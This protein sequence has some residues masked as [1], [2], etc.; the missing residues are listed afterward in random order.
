MKAKSLDSSGHTPLDLAVAGGKRV[1][2][3]ALIMSGVDV[4][5]LDATNDGPLHHAIKGGHVGIAKDLLLSGNNPMQARSNGDFPIHLAD[6]HGLDEA[7]LA[8]V[9]KGIDLNCVNN[10][11]DTPL[12]MAMVRNHVVT[13]KVLLAAG[14]DPN[15]GLALHEAASSNKQLPSER[16]SKPEPISM[17][18]VG[19]D[20]LTGSRSTLFLVCSH[21]SSPATGSQR[22]RE[23]P[24]RNNLGVFS[25]PSL[26]GRP[27]VEI[28][29]GR[30]DRG[31]RGRDRRRYGDTTH[32]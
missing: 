17:V 11:R 29:C 26:R 7:V 24:Q 23:D 8:L 18:R 14:A 6:W 4:D 25:R 9:Q 10:E 28:G 31:L 1:A 22:Q 12:C 30:D 32:P 16:F 3:K 2:V 27:V 13:K 15:S 21:A 5:A 19:R 20:E